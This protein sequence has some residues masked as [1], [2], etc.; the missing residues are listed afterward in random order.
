M[1]NCNTLYAVAEQAMACLKVACPKAYPFRIDQSSMMTQNV[2]PSHHGAETQSHAILPLLNGGLS[3]SYMLHAVL[4]LLNGGLSSSYMLHAVLTLL[5][6]GLSSSY[7]LHAV[8]TCPDML[9]MLH[10]LLALLN[11]G[12]SS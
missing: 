5:N 6:G 11:G 4:T 7:M 8:L 2:F 10:A 1:N 9:L 12:L 3:S